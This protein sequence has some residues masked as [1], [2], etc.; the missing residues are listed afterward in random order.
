MNQFAI[1]YMINPT[2]HVNKMFRDQ[3]EKCLRATFHHNTME[4]I[5]DVMR[6]KYRC[7]IAI[8]M[9]YDSKKDSIKMCGVIS[10]VLYYI[11]DNYVCIDYLCCQSKTLSSISSDK[12]SEQ[13]SYNILIGIVITEVFVNILSLHG[14][15]E[16]PN[17]TT[18]LN[19]RFSLVNYY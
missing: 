8:I 1:S 5:R 7:V 17:S 4:N 14:F 19:F 6:K 9:F 10:C 3:F 16:K 18:I 2:L 11:I 15:M 13:A 12:I